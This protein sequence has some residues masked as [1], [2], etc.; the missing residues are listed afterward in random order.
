MCIFTGG[1]WSENTENWEMANSMAG[2]EEE[3]VV[4]T[5]SPREVGEEAEIQQAEFVEESSILD[6]QDEW[7]SEAVGTVE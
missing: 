7:N 1:N 3:M 4:E 2:A 5:E 6:S